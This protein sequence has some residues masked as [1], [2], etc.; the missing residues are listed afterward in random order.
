M[1]SATGLE[2]KLRILDSID[3]PI[4]ELSVG[5]ICARVGISR[6]A[7]YNHFKSKYDILPWWGE[8]CAER[9]IFK[10]GVDYSWEE[11]YLLGTDLFHTK[12]DVLIAG[13]GHGDSS[14]YFAGY[15]YARRHAEVLRGVI[16][17][18]LGRA[19]DE[20][21][22]FCL[23]SFVHLESELTIFTCKDGIPVDTVRGVRGMLMVIPP[24]IY[25]NVQLPS[26][27]E[28]GRQACLDGLDELYRRLKESGGLFGA[29]GEAVA[30]GRS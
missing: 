4:D 13:F 18:R 29:A 17:G 3:R 5:D 2:T 11:G 10:I 9:Y 28:R 12:R 24:F 20:A 23:K 7:F 19:L 6:Q 22:E 15:P 27:L 16:E 8:H 25:D 14:P 1:S 26:W 21:E 30:E